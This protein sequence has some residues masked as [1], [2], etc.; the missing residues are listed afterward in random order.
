MLLATKIIKRDA[1]PK[2]KAGNELR[3]EPVSRQQRA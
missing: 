1:K 3:R 2:A